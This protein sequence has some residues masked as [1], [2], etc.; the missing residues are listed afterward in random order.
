M[1][2]RSAI[3]VGAITLASTGLVAITAP[4][5][6]QPAEAPA[7]PAALQEKIATIKKAFAESQAKLRTF[8][9]V[10]TTIVT[11]NGEEK[12]R[13]VDQC[14]Y[15]EEGTLVKVPISE[16]PPEGSD[17]E[18][19]IRGRIKERAKDEAKRYMKEAAGLMH[20]YLP[21]QPDLIQKCKDAGNASIHISDEGTRATLNFA[22]YL[23]EG[24]LV[25]IGL[26]L[27]TNR[28]VDTKVTTTMGEDAVPISLHATFGAFPDGTI[29]TEKT[30]LKNDAEGIAV[31]TENSGYR[32]MPT[33]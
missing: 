24:D 18:R 11:H 6:A 17:H 19:G 15:G 26:D 7:P 12:K 21:L 16:S 13:K 4:A 30:V 25:S 20:Q 8:E 2:I 28:P 14:Y 9:W 31:T 5:L 33:P 10:Q 22:N 3:L 32:P 27:A 23:H 29:F 1:S